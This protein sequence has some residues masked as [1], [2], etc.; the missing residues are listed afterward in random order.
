MGLNPPFQ[1]SGVAGI[2]GAVSTA[3]D[4]H[5]I[6]VWHIRSLILLARM[7]EKGYTY[8]MQVSSHGIKLAIHWPGG[9]LVPSCFWNG[10]GLNG[11]GAYKPPRF[12]FDPLGAPG[13]QGP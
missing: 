2:K 8:V 10:A 9:A 3:N 12:P 6:Q 13:P 7:V 5:V 4:V 1:V 11:A